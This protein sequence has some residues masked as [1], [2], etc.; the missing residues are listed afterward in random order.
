MRKLWHKAFMLAHH[1]VTH[2]S[3][4]IAYVFYYA[5]AAWQERGLVQVISGCLLI[6]AVATTI[7]G[8]RQKEG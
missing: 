5:F 6:F 8:S 1:P 2:H 4:H 7:E 3:H